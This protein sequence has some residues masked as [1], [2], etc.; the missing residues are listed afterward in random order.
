MKTARMAGGEPGFS[1]IEMLVAMFILVLMVMM[2]A[3]MFTNATQS[4]ETGTRKAEVNLIG[5]SVLDYLTREISK[6][7]F[8]TNADTRLNVPTVSGS[9]LSYNVLSDSTNGASMDGLVEAVTISL[10]GDRLMRVTN[11][12]IRNID[13]LIF[14][15]DPSDPDW[16]TYVD[17]TLKFR[18]SSDRARNANTNFVETFAK[19]VYFP[20]YH[21]SRYDDY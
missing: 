19:R 1:L 6:A 7:A 10:S 3:R 8:S 2:C 16:P 20:N 15:L 21:R 5:R 18:S 14:K 12:I 9:T 4:W 11:E 17:I 13:G